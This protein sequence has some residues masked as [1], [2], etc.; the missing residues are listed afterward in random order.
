MGLIQDFFAR[1]R[2]DRSAAS[3]SPGG[4]TRDPKDVIVK[5]LGLSILGQGEDPRSYVAPDFDLEAITE[6]Y[7]TEA[8][9]RQALD[10]YIEQMFKSGWNLVGKNVNAV[11]YIKHRFAVAAEATQTPTD[12][13]F[14]SMGEDLVKYSNVIVAKARNDSYPWPPTVQ[15]S[16]L[17]DRP[18]VVGY[19][20]LNVTT[21]SVRRDKNGM[22][23]GWEQEVE[24]QDRPVRFRAEDIVHIFYKREKGHAFGTPF[25]LPVLDDIRALRQAEENVLQLIYRNLY[26][27]YH[28]KVGS[29]EY[30][31]NDAEIQAVRATVESM[32]IEGGLVTSERHTITSIA[33]DKI[34]DANPYLDYFKARVFAGLGVPATLMG[35]GSTAN[36]STSD[37]MSTE[38]LD[39]V[40]AFQ[41]IL[42]V[43]IDE[44]IIKELLMEGGFDPILNPDDD[45]DFVFKE[46]DYDTKIKAENHAVFQY[47]HNAITEDEMRSLL[48]REPVT[49]RGQM[50]VN[51]VSIPSATA[52]A[53]LASGNDT[54]TREK[55]T[56]KPAPRKKEE[57]E[58]TLTSIYEELGFQVRS[59]IERR[60]NGIITDETMSKQLAGLMSMYQTNLLT[61]VDEKAHKHIQKLI[62]RTYDTVVD[63]LQTISTE[64]SLII[65]IDSIFQVLGNRLV[66][67][68][69]KYLSQEEVVAI[70]RH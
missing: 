17:G 69:Q 64:E 10:K 39:R 51:L 15:V 12:Q 11:Q 36:R 9:V 33:A 52:K 20:P 58:P 59:L 66:S 40:K 57:S 50:F 16:G 54:D 65:A 37:N 38:F 61:L 22:V 68:E 62:I 49:E 18:P 35:E 45:V 19:F 43:F 14:I 8:Y 67:I 4:K 32:E 60:Y 13:L 23:R 63:S 56:N 2:G 34:I 41:R 55:P 46:I 21:M 28:Y 42:A 26:P 31:A 44:F 7:R 3:S 25:L 70:E 47:E 48:G 5:P 1:F 6:A 27:F 24:G 53:E 29:D 30:P